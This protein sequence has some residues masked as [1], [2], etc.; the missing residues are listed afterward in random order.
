MQAKILD[1]R[2]H[3]AS[4]CCCCCHSKVCWGWGILAAGGSFHVQEGE[5]ILPLPWICSV[6]VCTSTITTKKLLLS[7][8]KSALGN[9]MKVVKLAELF[10]LS[11]LVELYITSNWKPVFLFSQIWLVFKHL[12]TALTQLFPLLRRLNDLNVHVHYN[13]IWFMLWVFLVC[14]VFFP[15]V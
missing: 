9:Q 6:Y 10:S 12:Y 11:Q 14:F 15:P 7:T 3:V 13:S 5:E 1:F 8:P 2:E 4:A